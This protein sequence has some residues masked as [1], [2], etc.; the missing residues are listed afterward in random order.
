MWTPASTPRFR[1]AGSSGRFTVLVLLALLLSACGSGGVI[2][3][4][5]V[6]AEQCLAVSG[7]HESSLSVLSPEEGFLRLRIVERGVSIVATLDANP[8]SAAESP[9]ERLGTIH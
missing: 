3:T 1:Q 9:V 2:Q 8:G 7:H 6:L 5:S 4:R